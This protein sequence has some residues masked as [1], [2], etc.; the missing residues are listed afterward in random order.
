MTKTELTAVLN[1]ALIQAA[2]RLAETLPPEEWEQMSADE[3]E[4]VIT[5]GAAVYFQGYIDGKKC[6]AAARK[7]A[8]EQSQAEQE[9][10]KSE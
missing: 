4:E 5:T 8:I 3:L 6:A 10:S 1:R 2:G 9:E 7:L